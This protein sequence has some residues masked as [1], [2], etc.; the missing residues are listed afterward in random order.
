MFFNNL[1]A[2]FIKDRD[3]ASVFPTTKKTVARICKSINFNNDIIVL[4]YGPGNGVFTKYLLSRITRNSKIIAVE[5]NKNLVALLDKKF[6]DRRLKIFND[7]AENIKEILNSEKINKVD[8]I[9]SGIPLSFLNFSE[10][11]KVVKDAYNILN[12]DGKFLIYQFSKKIEKL[13]SKYFNNIHYYNQ[14]LNIPPLFIFE[15]IKKRKKSTILDL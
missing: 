4:E 2:N 6:K 11:E 10:R 3:V 13:I 15:A 9:I 5:K 1:A 8:Y 14:P 12:D 7:S